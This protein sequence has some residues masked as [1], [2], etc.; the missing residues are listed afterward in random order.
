M[1]K[2]N[3]RELERKAYLWYHQDGILDIFIG[4]N[5]LLFSMWMLA[6]MAYLGGAFAA[7][8][9]PIYAQVK[10]QI[11]I[12]RLGY[13]K[14]AP[15]RIAKAKKTILLL[16]I[17]G[18]LALIP[19]VFLFLTT[20]RGML[21]PIQ[22]LVDYGMIVIGVVGMVLL[23]VVAYISEIRR[24]YA[25]SVLFVVIFTSGYFLSIPF[26]YYLMTV[27]VVIMVTGLYLLTQ[28]LHKYPLPS[29][30]PSDDRQ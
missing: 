18:V 22:F 12:P 15:S 20:Q 16:V 28:F 17:A 30:E 6:D 24:L 26:V 14:F 3:L 8:S 11:T 10:K 1:N 9:T 19:G 7:I 27:S 29:G 21:S 4:F 25:Y 5:I 13:V 23:A 2:I